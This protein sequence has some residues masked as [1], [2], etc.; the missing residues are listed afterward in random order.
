[1]LLAPFASMANA[2]PVMSTQ[3]FTIPTSEL[4]V[5]DNQHYLSHNGTYLQLRSNVDGQIVQSVQCDPYFGL[6]NPFSIDATLTYIM[7]GNSAYDYGNGTINVRS[8]P[9]KSV[10]VKQ[11]SYQI[12]GNLYSIDS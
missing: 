10:D 9:S 11:V 1:M 12:N 4:V 3:G 8:I 5:L 2:A 6:D 7:C